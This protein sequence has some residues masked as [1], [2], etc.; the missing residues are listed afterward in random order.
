ML[1]ES[2]DQLYSHIF[3]IALSLYRQCKHGLLLPNGETP[4]FEDVWRLLSI[5]IIR[6]G[7]DPQQIL[8]EIET[9][10]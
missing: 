9:L 1:Y 5:I 2:K 10:Y 8:T 4:L 6:E 3:T 7:F